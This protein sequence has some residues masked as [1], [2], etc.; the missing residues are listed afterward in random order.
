MK[1]ILSRTR[2]AVDRY[3]MI[4]DG[5][6]VAVG[7]SGGKDSLVLLCALARLQKFYPNRFELKA[8][9]ADPCFGC[10]PGDFSAVE[11]LCAELGVE[12]I[13]RRTRLYEIIF[14]ERK[15]KNPC[16]LCSRMRRGLLSRIARE[17]GCD[18]LALGHHY[19]DAAQTVL[20]NI[21]HG[22]KAECFSAKAYL[23]RSEIT[24]IRPLIFCS[25]G[26]VRDCG[27]RLGLPVVKSG[28]PADG[29]TERA[30]IAQTIARLELDY[31]DVKSK[32]ISAG[33]LE[34]F[35]EGKQ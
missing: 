21:L 9:T 7:V 24:A 1:N 16:S 10:E 12:Y 20:M 13:I 32:L 31:P 25:E 26:M 35:S 33:G 11:R 3:N 18:T 19:D 34:V 30:R 29:E 8:I 6:S 15:E 17:E 4:P 27:I 5:A 2:A 22:G 14:L 23:S 28:C